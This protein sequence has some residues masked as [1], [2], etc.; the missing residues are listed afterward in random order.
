M[1]PQINVVAPIGLT[2]KIC[3]KIMFSAPLLFDD[4][5]SIK[6]DNIRNGKTEGIITLKHNIIPFLTDIDIDFEA[7]IDMT[8]TNHG[9]AVVAMFIGRDLLKMFA[10]LE[11]EAVI[12]LWSPHTF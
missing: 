11:Q 1:L 5:N 9:I 3:D 10:I 7:T 8:I 6:S 2:P 12:F 4:K